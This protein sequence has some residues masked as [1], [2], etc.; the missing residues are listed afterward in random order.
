[1]NPRRVYLLC[2][3]TIGL[4]LQAGGCAKEDRLRMKA[5]PGAS[6]FITESGKIDLDEKI[7]KTVLV[8]SH[9][10]R[11]NQQDELEV[12]ISL[13]ARTSKGADIK[14]TTDFYDMQGQLLKSTGPTD[15][16]L[17][18][19]RA[20]QLEFRAAE[21]KARRYLV[22]IESQATEKRSWWSRGSQDKNE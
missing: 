9:N 5:K 12:I 10:S 19:D 20:E 15:H 21:P 3:L 1:M 17:D 7:E 18:T 6:T 13:T 11:R 14:V 2:L 4:A 16:A 22:R 8:L